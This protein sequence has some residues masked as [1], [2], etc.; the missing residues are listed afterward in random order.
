MLDITLKA[1]HAFCQ[2]QA[3]R[4]LGRKQVCG[5]EACGKQ[6]GALLWQKQPL[7]NVCMCVSLSRRAEGLLGG[8]NH[9]HHVVA[10]L[11]ALADEVHV[12]DAYLVTIEAVVDVLQVLVLQLVAVIVDFVLDI[13]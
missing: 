4:R 8:L 9:I 7:G 3:A 13:V 6:R 11:L 2:T 5:E 10:Q 1:L 12:I